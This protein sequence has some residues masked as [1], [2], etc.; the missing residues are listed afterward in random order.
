VSVVGCSGS[1]KTTVALAL[2]SSLDCPGHE[3]DGIFH[4]PGWT[5]L[6]R[7]QFRRRVHEMTDAPAWVIDG[8]YGAVRDIV[9]DHADT[10]VWL[11]LPYLT[12]MSRVIRRTLRRT[13]RRTE[14]WNGNREPL[15]NLVSLNPQ[16]SIIMWSATRHGPARRKFTEAMGDP[17]W[18][19][20]TFI[21]LRSR[22]DVREFVRQAGT[23]LRQGAS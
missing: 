5:E 18:S 1:G 11:D 21:R 12:V 3:L 19:H 4:Q 15:S 23:D 13:I 16:K 8:N 9:W 7:D 17:A 14:L 2:A 10:V 6:P 20:L 22:S